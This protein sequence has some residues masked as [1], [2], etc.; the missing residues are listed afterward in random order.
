MKRDAINLCHDSQGKWTPSTG[1]C[2]ARRWF[3]HSGQELCWNGEWM[4]RIA[5][6][7][8]D[9]KRYVSKTD[10]IVGLL[11]WAQLPIKPEKEEVRHHPGQSWSC[12]L[13]IH[14]PQEREVN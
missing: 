12:K 14:P 9:S 7:S 4:V 10:V 8:V 2:R 5:D 6:S 1:C 11:V 3:L 13:G